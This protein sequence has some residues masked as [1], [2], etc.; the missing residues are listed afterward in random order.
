[1]AFLATGLTPNT[2]YWFRVRAYN[3]VGNS[4][5]T[6]VVDDTTLEAGDY[7]PTEF[8]KWIRDPSIEP[9]YLAEINPKMPFEGFPF[10]KDDDLVL[11]LP[12][13]EGTG[14]TAY[15]KSKYGNNGSLENME[16]GDWVDGVVGKALDFEID[17]YVNIPGDPSLDT[18]NALTVEAWIY[19]PTEDQGHSINKDDGSANRVWIVRRETNTSVNWH[20]WNSDD[21]VT[22]FTP[23]DSWAKDEW[24][25]IACTAKVVGANI[26]MEVIFN[27][28]S[29]GT[30]SFPGTAI[31]V[32]TAHAIR[33]S[34]SLG[35][36]KRTNC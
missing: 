26:V 22:G 10:M 12:F 3:G 9:V 4:G 24:F 11:C 35:A 2:H 29:K 21:V 20:V 8:E 28:V 7:T 15:D 33:I 16:E 13:D 14:V 17:D 30:T 31:K 36:Y 23:A 25:H 5:Y 18:P 1:T 32:A 19:D 6:N 34:R 27:G